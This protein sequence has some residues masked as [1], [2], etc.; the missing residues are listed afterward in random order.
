MNVDSHGEAGPKLNPRRWWILG[1]VQISTLIVGMAITATNVVMPQVR[2]T[3]SSTQDQAAW[4]VTLFLAAAAVATPLTGWLAGRLGWRR[5]M[6]ST[7]IGFTVSSFVCGVAGSLEILLL[8]RIG[9][10]LF[11]A[12]LMPLGL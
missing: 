7:M 5:L 6:V 1:L 12:P 8:G 4:I 10:G 9:Q 11:S 3:L 2:G